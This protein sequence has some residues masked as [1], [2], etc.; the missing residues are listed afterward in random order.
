MTTVY[1]I[2]HTQPDYNIHEDLIRPLS[3][4][5]LNDRLLVTE[6]LMDKEINV[7]LSS[8]YKRAVDTVSDFA[9]RKNLSVN[10]VDDFRER[11]VDSVWIEDFESF[12]AMQWA[13]FLYKLSDGECLAQVQERNI[14]ALNKVLA[15]YKDQNIV[16]G[17]HGTALSTI[18]NFYDNSYNYDDFKAMVNIMPWVVKMTFDGN[19]CAGMEKIDLFKPGFKPDPDQCKVCTFDTG[20]L[21]A[22]RFVVIFA[23]YCDKWL[24]CRA[25]DRNTYETAGGHIEQGE[26]PYDAAK[27]ELYEETGAIGFE[28]T[29]AFDYSVHRPNEYS[30]GQ[31]YFA[32]IQ[33]LGDMPGYEMAEVR[34]FD[35][36]PDVMRFPMILPVLYERLQL[37]DI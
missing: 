13:D 11:K 19:D 20:T 26:T 28:L 22:Y 18:I 25:K 12:S 29:S 32:R 27:R 16:I 35:T 33:E 8:P 10:T 36:I 5:G 30:N 4:K 9:E 15:Q 7:I 17:T 24:Y 14:A 2:R 6:F 3:E 34:M 31:V 21:K 23:R 1:F 37:S